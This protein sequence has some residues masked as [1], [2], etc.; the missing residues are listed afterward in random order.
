MIDDKL[1]HE[2]TE[3]EDTKRIVTRE[4]V[5]RLKSG[6]KDDPI[7]DIEET[8]GFEDF[9]DELK[10]FRQT[11]EANWEL[12][13]RR[14]EAVWREKLASDSAML[15]LSVNA[16]RTINCLTSRLDKLEEEVERLISSK[17]LDR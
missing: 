6:W 8:P 10:S 9:R 14:E 13:K 16:M 11:C 7:W 5:D 2:E 17:C 4:D 1:L 15:E 3:M 12:E